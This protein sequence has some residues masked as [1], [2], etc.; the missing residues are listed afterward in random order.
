MPL[1]LHVIFKKGYLCC[2][3]STTS[4]QFS[5]DSYFAVVHIAN[6]NA[7]FGPVWPI[8]ISVAT[9]QKLRCKQT[10]LWPGEVDLSTIETFKNVSKRI[11]HGN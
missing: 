6:K 11:C 10:L 8:E 2:V 4:F 3:C 1:K 9:D 5:Y 7:R